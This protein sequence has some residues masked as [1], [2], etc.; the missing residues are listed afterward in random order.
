MIS[1]SKLKGE[2]MKNQNQLDQILADLKNESVVSGL[3]AKFDNNEDE[4][5]SE[6]YKEISSKMDIPFSLI[7]SKGD[8]RI[9]A[10]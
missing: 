3:F 6:L 9:E 2:N 8:F 10:K 7:Y 1:K 5:A 4:V